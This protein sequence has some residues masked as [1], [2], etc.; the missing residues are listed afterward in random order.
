MITSMDAVISCTLTAV[1]WCACGYIVGEY[2]GMQ[3]RMSLKHLKAWEKTHGLLLPGF[4]CTSCGAFTGVAKE[5]LLECRC[6]GTP[7]PRP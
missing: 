1:V 3:K 5:E 6:C 4:V 2:V 7:R